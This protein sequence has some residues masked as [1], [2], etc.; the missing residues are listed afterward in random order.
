MASLLTDPSQLVTPKSIIGMLYGQ[1]GS[2]K[3]TTALSAPNCVLLDFDRGLHRIKPQYRVPSLQVENYEEVLE[4]IESGELASFDTIVID[5][6]GKLVDRIAEYVIRQNP[7]NG[8]PGH[9]P[10][11]QGWGEVKMV[12]GAFVKRVRGLGKSVIFVCHESEEK[13]GDE[14]IKRPDMAGSSRKDVV[15]EMDFMG[16]MQLIGSQPVINFNPTATFYAK[17]SLEL[18]ASIQVPQLKDDMPND[19]LSRYLFKASDAKL[20]ADNKLRQE[21]DA[22][23][24]K[25]DEDI[26]AIKTPADANAFYAAERPVLWASHFHVRKAL[27]ARTDALAIEFDR[28]TKQFVAK[29]KAEKAPAEANLSSDEAKPTKKAKDI[30]AAKKTG[31]TAKAEKLAEPVKQVEE[32]TDEAFAAGD[33]AEA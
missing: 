2:Q 7:K 32:I 23:I 24:A 17:N 22:L 31:R 33:D 26:A 29:A 21:Y 28:T 4:L 3:T 16:Y 10:S 13:N 25:I 6:G 14:T 30:P 18:D 20:A 5:T 1:P 27:K 11:Q 9:G 8:R 15:K 19:F 12:F